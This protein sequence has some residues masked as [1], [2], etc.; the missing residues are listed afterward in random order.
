MSLPPP[1]A[2]DRYQLTTILYKFTIGLWNSVM[3]SIADRLTALEA[4]NADYQEVIDT[5]TDAAIEFIQN[6]VTPQLNQVASNIADLNQ[7]IA[8][9]Q[10]V[11]DALQTA[12]VPAENVPVTPAGNFPAGTSVQE[13][14]EALD[15]ATTGIGNSLDTHK[16]SIDVHPEARATT[17]LGRAGIDNARIMTPFLVRDARLLRSNVQAGAYTAVAADFGQTITCSGTWTLSLTAAA[18]LGDG[19]YC[20]VRNTGTGTITVDPNGAE[21]IDGA[22]TLKVR[23]GDAIMV[24]CN[25]STFRTFGRGGDRAITDIVALTGNPSA[26]QITSGLDGDFDEVVLRFWDLTTTGDASLSLELRRTS[27]SVWNSNYLVGGQISVF[28]SVGGGSFSTLGQTSYSAVS[29]GEICFRGLNTSTLRVNY[30]MT[31]RYQYS[32]YDTYHIGGLRG[33]TPVNGIRLVPYQNNG[34]PFTGGKYQ[35]IGRKAS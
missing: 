7:E 19:W 35:L 13:A 18:T 26:I 23:P 24:H 11:L 30:E 31:G 9:A 5:G 4:R 3:G 25:G 1:N 33:S 27:D 12:G 29:F 6:S 14:L 21:T 34:G 32:G 17:A 2:S 10:D 8:E 28:N 22:A 16:S 15:L 20:Y